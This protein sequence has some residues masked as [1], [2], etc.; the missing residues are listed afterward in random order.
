MTDMK[1]RILYISLFC[2]YVG[3]VLYLCLMKPDNL[4]DMEIFLFGLPA[5]KILHF[6]M[7]LP[8][9]IISYLVFFNSRR[10][11]AADIALLFAVICVGTG[12]AVG[13]EAL[14]AMTQYRS[15]D[16]ND[17]YAD[18]T[19]L[20][21]GAAAVLLYILAIKKTDSQKSITEP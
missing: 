14:Q 6:T 5:D 15:A 7:F 10:K 9:P 16:I 12:A 1:R 4:P 8:F 18:V 13:T 21:T 17:F 11:T 2:I 3:A 19:G 20:C